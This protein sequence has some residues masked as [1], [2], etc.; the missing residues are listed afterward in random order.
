MNNPKISVIVPVYNVEKYIQKCVGS[1]IGQAYSNL[2]IILVD[3]GSPDNSGQM[4]DEYAATDSRITVIHKQNGGVS[5][6]RNAGLDVATGEYVVFVDADDYLAEDYMQYMLSLVANT[7]AE[8]CLSK[9]CFMIVG[10]E[11]IAEDIVKIYNPD[12]ATALLLSPDVMVGCWNKIYKRSLIGD[13]RF[14]EKLFFG[15][16][17]NF[18]TSISQLANS[19]GVGGRKVYYYRRNNE[20]SATTKFNIEKFYN[21]EKAIENIKNNLRLY[22]PKVV[23]MLTLHSCLFS[24][25][26][27]NT[28]IARCLKK[29]FSNDYKRWK[30]QVKH[31]VP[32]LIV[33]QG[34]S[35]Y[36][37]LKLLCAWVSPWLMMKL[38]ITKR[39][40]AFKKSVK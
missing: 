22:S 19:I 32:R 8:F 35:T 23:T 17:L 37:K 13:L 9:H 10:E 28:L 34:I 20:D 25:Q 15:E 7:R 21:G 6:A 30:M 24:V 5:S 36:T 14:S 38:S 2:E 27:L 3:D 31:D 11:Q 26:A 33:S 12:E 16:G 39:K 4:C 29:Q 40:Y 18:I 1:I